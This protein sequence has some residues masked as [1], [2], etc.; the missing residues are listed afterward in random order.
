MATPSSEWPA[1]SD[2]VAALRSAGCVFAEDEAALLRAE[3]RTPQH[4]AEL[5]A[6][7]VSGAPLEHV[8]G[9]VAFSGLRIVVTP[10]VFVP[11]RRTELLVDTARRVLD[12]QAH[13]P[14][15]RRRSD[16]R[17]RGGRESVVVDLCCGSGAVGVAIATAREPVELHAVDID[18]VAVRC[19]RRNIPMT[20]GQVHRGDLDEPLPSSLRGRVD[21][22]TANAP[23][24]PTH[25]LRL[26]P[27]EA[28]QHE[29][30]TALDGGPEGLDLLFRV[31]ALA[32]RW[33]APGGA[34][35]MEAGAAQG[36]A[37]AAAL[38]AAGLTPT[39]VQDAERDAT[40]VS[41]SRAGEDPGG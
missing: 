40:V 28:R 29:P 4:L 14:G 19:A 38:T 6:R 21:I 2:V 27:P 36:V 8:L 25:A 32:P 24:V 11:R 7:R 41:G 34:V 37:L 3:A 33:L 26:M 18:P 35:L 1:L 15:P 9:W 10:G 5:T 23:Y 20:L 13:R 22:L 16:G 12:E 30:R 17:R 39:V 31:I